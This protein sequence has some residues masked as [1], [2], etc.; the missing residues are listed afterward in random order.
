MMRCKTEPV[1]VNLLRSPEIDS[2]P[3]GPEQQLYLSHR[4]A[5][6]IPGLL[7]R[8]QIRALDVAMETSIVNKEHTFLS[9]VVRN[10]PNQP[11]PH[12]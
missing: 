7:K 5:E 1:F 3:G 10:T 8:L 4:L 9:S 2:H 6:S 11:P 12:K